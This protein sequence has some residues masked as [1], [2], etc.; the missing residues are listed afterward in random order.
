[1]VDLNVYQ[2]LQ[3][4]SSSINPRVV[5]SYCLSLLNVMLR[6]VCQPDSIDIRHKMTD[7][8]Y[9]LREALRQ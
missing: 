8:Q 7:V 6:V 9:V 4:K 5:N 2:M 1:M 3:T